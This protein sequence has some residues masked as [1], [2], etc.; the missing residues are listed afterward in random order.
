MSWLVVDLFIYVYLI[1]SVVGSEGCSY[2]YAIFLS[3][4]VNNYI[5]PKKR[6]PNDGNSAKSIL[7]LAGR[8]NLGWEFFKLHLTQTI[9]SQ[10]ALLLTNLFFLG[11]GLWLAVNS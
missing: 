2:L 5:P 9:F 10:K 11:E 6:R 8:G 7:F 3:E 1:L 4:E